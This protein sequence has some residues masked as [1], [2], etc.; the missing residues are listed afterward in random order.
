MGHAH[1]NSLSWTR[2]SFDTA[3]DKVDSAPPL[4]RIGLN[5]HKAG[6]Q[7]LDK[8]KINQAGIFQMLS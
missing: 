3:P 2:M 4:S 6:M 8:E 7:G 5:D 1:L